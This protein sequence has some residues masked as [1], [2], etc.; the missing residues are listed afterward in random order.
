ME[1]ILMK[2]RNVLLL[3]IGVLFLC[4]WVFLIYSNSLHSPFQ[5]DDQLF[6]ARNDR[7]KNLNNI[8]LVWEDGHQ[9]RRIISFLSFSLNY[10]FSKENVFGYHLVNT[11]IH[12][13]SALAT[14]WLAV[15]IIAF[16][17]NDRSR[18]YLFGF[19]CTFIFCSSSV[20]RS[21]DVY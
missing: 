12:I 7:I 3:I 15:L 10:H 13:F 1:N 16:V 19:F 17:R 9:R 2:N 18:N 11:I 8:N 14:W 4:S 20:D 6:I 5:F 21:C